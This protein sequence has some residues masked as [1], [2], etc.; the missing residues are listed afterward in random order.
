MAIGSILRSFGKCRG[1]LVH[2]MAFWYIFPHIGMLS[3]EKSGSPESQLF[4]LLHRRT[5]RGD[6][7]SCD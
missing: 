5:H 1:H 7:R 4:S 6:F 2:F 3:Q